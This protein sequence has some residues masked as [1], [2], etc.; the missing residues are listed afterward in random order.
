MSL[1]LLT[2]ASM[3]IS[4]LATILSSCVNDTLINDNDEL[5]I[6][7]ESSKSKIPSVPAG[8]DPNFLTFFSNTYSGDPTIAQNSELNPDKQFIKMVNEAKLSIDVC[9]YHVDSLTITQAL[10]NAYKRG[11]KV[12]M[13][14]DSDTNKKESV[15]LLRKSGITVVD[16]Q[17]RTAFMHN[18][19][20]IVDKTIVWTGSFN[21]TDS[22]SWKHCD[23]AIKI[24]NEYLAQNYIAE[25]EEMFVGLN[26]GKRSPKN[27]ENKIVR[28]GNKFVKTFFAPEEDV[29][30]G[31]IS[32]IEKA[33]TDIKF[34][35]YSFTHE[36]IAEAVI[37]RA[38]KGVK[39]SGV[40]EFLGS[41]SVQTNAI[42]NTLLQSGAELYTYKSPNS[43][44]SFMH[45]KVFIIDGKTVST[46]SFN[47]THSASNENDENMLVIHSFDTAKE[48]TDEFERLKE[49]S[50]L[51]ILKNSS[52]KK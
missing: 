17:G 40:F 32:E 41:G 35:A 52:N 14:I 15:Q 38:K 22:A 16:D 50:T 28:I 5:N 8:K 1:R 29:V 9:A 47:F 19:F 6:F 48:Y 36:K 49:N 23:N 31:I 33:K 12:R 42:Y 20:A 30:D 2:K 51:N 45:H 27:V 37:K 13:V 4:I 24:N 21:L 10:I 44:T 39:V 34:M 46:G 18:K 25:F 3:L 43:S 11:I 7:S 26:F